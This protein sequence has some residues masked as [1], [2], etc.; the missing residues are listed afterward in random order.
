[1]ATLLETLG[2]TPLHPSPGMPPAPAAATGAASPGPPVSLKMRPSDATA[3]D[4]KLPA[5]PKKQVDLLADAIVK[6]QDAAKRDKLVVLLRDA[7]VKIPPVMSDKDARK[8]IDKAIDSLIESGSKKL[9]LSLIE[10]AVGKKATTMPDDDKRAQTGPPLKEKDLGEHILKSPEI[11]IGKPPAVHRNSFEFRGLPRSARPSS[12]IDFTLRTP[13]WFEPYGRMGA[14]WVLIM[15]ADDYK[16]N[17]DGAARLKDRH[18]EQ[19]GELKLSLAMPDDPGNYVIAIKVGPS[20][21]SY[22]VENIEIKK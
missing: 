6:V 3:T 18:I 9:L 21:E 10:A 12:Y 1:M 11:P 15:E 13:D 17:R 19:K 16:K 8:A 14:G 20:L 2:L 5:D 4:A 7:L 22:P